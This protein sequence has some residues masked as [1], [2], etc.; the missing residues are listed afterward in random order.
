MHQ[1]LVLP[2]AV[3]VD[4]AL[5]VAAR[6]PLQGGIERHA[7]GTWWKTCPAPGRLQVGQGQATDHLV[8]ELQESGHLVRA[9][10]AGAELNRLCKSGNAVEAPPGLLA[11]V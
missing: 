3:K 11:T 4:R 1:L 7:F 6:V 10:G 8:T 9:G 2:H 5:S